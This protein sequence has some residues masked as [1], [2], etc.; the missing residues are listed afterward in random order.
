MGKVSKKRGK[1]GFTM[2]KIRKKRGKG[3]LNL[4]KSIKK[5][6]IGPVFCKKHENSEPGIE[7]QKQC[8]VT[9]PALAPLSL[10]V[11]YDSCQGK[12]EG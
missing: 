8:T 2:G 1:V 7:H 10:A 6:V 11:L 5:K 4:G 12:Q 3:D 9:L